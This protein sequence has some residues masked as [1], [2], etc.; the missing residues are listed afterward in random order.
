MMAQ[1]E[2]KRILSESTYDHQIEGEKE[3]ESEEE[4]EK[5]KELTK[6][7]NTSY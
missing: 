1:V 5:E 7:K 2:E 6:M 4:K 3:R